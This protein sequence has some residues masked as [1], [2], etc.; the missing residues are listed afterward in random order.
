MH[1][2]HFKGNTR[3]PLLRIALLFSHPFL[4]PAFERNLFY[5]I[6]FYSIFVLCILY[7]RI[8]NIEMS[9]C[10]L[11]S[12][13]MVVSQILIILCCVSCMHMHVC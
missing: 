13:F 10:V 12:I 7:I 4:K 1:V 3:R 11:Y 8:V 5:S 2:F 9:E 6:L